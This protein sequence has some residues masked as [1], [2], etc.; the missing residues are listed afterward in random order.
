MASKEMRVEEIQQHMASEEVRMN[1][2]RQAGVKPDLAM[3]FRGK[4]SRQSIIAI[5]LVQPEDLG[6]ILPVS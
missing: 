4:G 6:K 1:S 2:N 5:L 3:S